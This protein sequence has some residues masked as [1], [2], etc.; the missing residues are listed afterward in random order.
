MATTSATTGSNIDVASIVS[1]LMTVEKRP[2]TVLAQKEA[3]YSAKLSAIGSLQGALSSFQSAVAGLNDITKF[4]SMTAAPS[5]NTALSASA[6]STAAAGSYSINVTSLAQSQK[7]VAVGQTSAT[8]SIGSGTSTTLTFDFGSITGGAFNATAGTYTGSTFTSNGSGTKTVTIDATNNSLQG[9]RDAINTANIGVSATIINDGS[10]TPYRL[11]LSSSAIGSSN[12][13]KISVAG[14][15][16]LGTLLNH[17]P[18]ATQN[19]S[20]TTTAQ[21]ANF[22][23]NGVAVSKA[24]NTVSDVIQG[25]TL[26][27]LKTTTTATNLTVAS[28]NASI[29]TAVSGFVKAYNDLN[30]TLR[31]VSKYDPATQ[32]GAILQGDAVVL[33][34]QSQLR[35]AMNTPVSGAGAL[36]N[37][38]QIGVTFQKDG[39]MA[40]DSTKLSAAIAS[41]FSNIASLFATTGGASDSLISY[42]SAASTVKPGSYAVN[43]TQLATQGNITGLAAAGTTITAGTNDALSVSINGISTSVTLTAGTYTAVTLAAEVQAKINGASA[44]SSAGVSVTVTQTGG[45]FSITSS[46]YGSNSSVA[47]SGTGAAGLLGG[48]PTPI[49]GL[50]VAGTIDGQNATGSGQ[51]LTAGTGNALGLKIQVSGGAL[52]ARG[53]VNYSKGYGYSLSNL[54]NSMLASDGLIAGKKKGINNSITDIGKQRDA[55]NVRLAAIQKRYTAQFSALDVMLSSMNQTSNYLSTQLANLSYK[56]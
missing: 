46:N 5:D 25:V 27:L 44:L 15:A 56:Y 51:F 31:N 21:N 23:V 36:T 12:S 42:S 28:D 49:A 48:A 38:T 35:A 54:A 17:D 39:S 2:L 29:Q 4:R 16:A 3:S 20:E 41:N 37:L 53:T 9:I 34:I 32:T 52:G 33:G 13:L 19:L 11:A 45:V 24:S 14:D 26:S 1:Q 22:T 43:I 55:L 47:I 6:I 7:L 40:V 50:D 8:A 30:T 18:A 10:G